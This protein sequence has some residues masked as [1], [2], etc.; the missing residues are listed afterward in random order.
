MPG[1]PSWP[2]NKGAKPMTFAFATYGQASK[3]IEAKR[4]P[5]DWII[6][7][8]DGEYRIIWTKPGI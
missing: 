2:G 8:Q 7:A 6:R 3:A 4:N 1:W 5:A